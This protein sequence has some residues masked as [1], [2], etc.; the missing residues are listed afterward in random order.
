MRHGRPQR[1]M[2]PR[3]ILS[4]V[5]RE[6]S[7]RH[8]APLRLV[9]LVAVAAATILAASPTAAAEPDPAATTAEATAATAGAAGAEPARAPEPPAVD[10][11][12]DPASADT[13]DAAAADSAPAEPDRATEPES[14]ADPAAA[15]T[16][17][18]EPASAGVAGGAGCGPL[19][20]ESV[21]VD[22]ADGAP[23]A[24]AY[25]SG[26]G[27][28]P[29]CTL[30]VEVTR[31]DGSV[32]TGE[33][34][35]SADGALSYDHPL[36]GIGGPHHVRVLATDRTELATT[37]FSGSP[38]P[39]QA[40]DDQPGEPAADPAAP[41]S[42][43]EPAAEPAASDPPATAPAPAPVSAAAR[44][45]A[46]PAGATGCAPLGSETV[47]TDKADYAPGET[48]HMTGAGYAPA[49]TVRVEVTRP[50]GSVVRGDGTF[51]PGV[52][53]VITA[54]D[55]TLAYDYQLNGIEG[56]YRVRVLGAGD[57]ELAITT[58]TDQIPAPRASASDPRATF[59]P[60]NLTTCSQVGLASPPT[61]QVG[62]DDSNPA[63]DDNVAGTVSPNSGLV[64]GPAGQG[65]E[66]N[67]TILGTGVVVDAVVVKG[68]DGSNVYNVPAVLPPAL[69]PPQHY[70][71]PFSGSGTIPDI[72][73]WFICYHLEEVPPVGSLTVTKVNV[74]PEGLPAVPIP[75][76]FTVT[77]TCGELPPVTVTFGSGGGE[78]DPSPAIE[79]VPASTVCTVVEDTTG[80][81]AEAFVSYDPPGA[82]T[83]GVPIDADE[84]TFVTVTND[85][86]GV[87]V[88]TGFLQIVKAVEPGVALPAELSVDVACDDETTAVVTVPGSGGV[89]EPVL[90]LPTGT[91][92]NVQEV[93]GD[94][95]E[96]TVVTYS[97]DGG[98]PTTEVPFTVGPIETGETLTVTITNDPPE[99]PP[100]C[101]GPAPT[102]SV[103]TAPT[104]GQTPA[105]PAQPTPCPAPSPAAGQLPATGAGDLEGLLLAAGA[106][107][108]AG[109][110]VRRAGAT[111]RSG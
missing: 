105:Q 95:P 53:E 26:S 56:L 71:S 50:D 58:F 76:T 47:A 49:C 75:E 52:D 101:P 66:L 70:I 82:D 103:P 86:S 35:T 1:R 63:S 39:G 17:T 3:P 37:T 99:P 43:P 74:L 67:V 25:V 19:G 10:P 29:G 30:R 5:T 15:D 107:I 98:E 44:A 31:P 110:L 46:A 42:A 64:A 24:T 40:T 23:G 97:V 106:L 73:H 78:G 28:A 111:A 11:A 55:G 34:T 6:Q 33:V 21:A 88:L 108:V 92:C 45:P 94:L 41:A 87:P 89:G 83:E 4:V 57:T 36:D 8:G 9:S 61:I 2:S 79:D 32:A 48:V 102:P 27:Y 85:F 12:A 51:E 54:A 20:S 38:P 77:V 22:Q 72:S 91:F 14:S 16:A 62:E 80:F 18:T 69:P 13:A 90:T 100:P 81:P 68:A 7:R 96:G 60:V 104:P 59:V 93:T 84:P 109:V 65:Q